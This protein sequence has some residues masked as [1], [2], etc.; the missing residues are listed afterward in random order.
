MGAKYMTEQEARFHRAL[1][2]GYE[3]AK[4][5]CKYNATYF[6]GMVADSGAVGAVKRLLAKDSVSDGFG[7]LYLCGRLD[8]T[9]EA[10]V[11]RPEFADL[12]TPEEIAVAQRRLKEYGYKPV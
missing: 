9:V 3:T 11:V 12:F 8:L 7:T 10:Y 5:E 1:M 2:D 6:L 4:R